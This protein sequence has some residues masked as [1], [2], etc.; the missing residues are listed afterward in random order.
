M[1]DKSL[2]FLR[3][4]LNE[5]IKKKFELTQDKV[6]LSSIVKQDG[7]LDNELEDDSISIMLINVQ[8]ESTIQSPTKHLH[9][10]NSELSIIN[11]DMNINLGILIIVNFTHYVESMKFLTAVF[12]FFQSKNVFSRA[13]I[14]NFNMESIDE[15]R[16]RFIS[17]TQEQQNQL[18]G[19]LGAKYMPSALYKVRLIKIQ[20]NQIREKIPQIT[21]INRKYIQS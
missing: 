16:T 8:E 1:I 11:P 5:H 13:N 19:T 3:D 18:W 7:K 4:Q 17:Q 2:E 10:E 12:G 20:E 14:T 15:I 21:T 6:Q 9:L